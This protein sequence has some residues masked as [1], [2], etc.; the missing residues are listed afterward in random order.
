MAT[1]NLGVIKPV[2]KGAYNNSTAYVLDNIVTSGGSS[3]ICILASTGNAVSNATY[4]S[5]LA[6]GTGDASDLTTGTL[7]IARIADDAITNAKMADDA[8]D[9]A[10][11]ADGAID[12]AHMSVNSI[13]SDSYVDG[14]IDNAH[15]AD[16]AVGVAELSATGTA[17]SS[18]FLRGDNTWVAPTGGSNQLVG[19]QLYQGTDANASTTSATWQELIVCAYTPVSTDSTIV[20]S[21]H[22]NAATDQGHSD[23]QLGF[24][25]NRDS[26]TQSTNTLNERIYGHFTAMN[27]NWTLWGD[28]G[29][30]AFYT[31]SSTTAKTFRAWYNREGAASR[32]VFAHRNE[33]SA[34]KKFVIIQ[35]FAN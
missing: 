26:S 18:T 7:P 31:N 19:W 12:A 8:I 21:Y 29:D 34:N 16:D 3:Y 6:A 11:I 25:W 14:S 24:S 9:S 1:V 23:S 35:E 17:S 33:Q 2:F 4:W 20:M 13:D 10:Q 15:L 32:S 22:G 27:L 28:I 5:T 30:T